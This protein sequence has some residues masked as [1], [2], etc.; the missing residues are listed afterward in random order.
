MWHNAN[1][2]S[3][4]WPPSCDALPT[5]RNLYI[6]HSLVIIFFREEIKISPTHTWQGRVHK[7]RPEGQSSFLRHQFDSY[8]WAVS[9]Q[10]GNRGMT[11]VW[12]GL[13]TGS[14]WQASGT[15]DSTMKTE[16]LFS[17]EILVRT[18]R[19][20]RRHGAYNGQVF[21]DQ[22]TC[23]IL[24]FAETSP[25]TTRSS[26]L[27]LTLILRRSRTGTVWFYTSTSNKRA[28]RPKLYT[29]SLTRDL[30]LMYSRL[31]VVRISINL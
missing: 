2:H 25:L 14:A 26:W 10:R 7:R 3:A 4:T 21:G 11:A 6:I 9:R 12:T 16:A 27:P 18:H 23:P 17:S 5:L 13:D 15:G 8:S 28:A 24:T 22:S 30:M 1:T 19:T 29:K 31:T 20:I